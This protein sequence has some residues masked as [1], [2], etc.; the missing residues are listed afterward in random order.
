MKAVIL[1]GEIH[2]LV[3]CKNSDY[4]PMIYKFLVP[5][6]LVFLSKS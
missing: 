6:L 2:M 5:I 1:A 3:N 4:N